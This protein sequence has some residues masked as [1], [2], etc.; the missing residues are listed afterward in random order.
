MQMLVQQRGIFGLGKAAART[1][2][3]QQV[4]IIVGFRSRCR[5]HDNGCR[6]KKLCGGVLHV[7]SLCGPRLSAA[8]VMTF[9]A[10]VGYQPQDVALGLRCVHKLMVAARDGDDYS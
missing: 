5:Q 4:G 3:I 8:S 2:H 9:S 6:R 7:P 1:Q 10:Q